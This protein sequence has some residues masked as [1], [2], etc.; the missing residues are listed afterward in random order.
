MVEVGEQRYAKRFVLKL[1]ID[2]VGGLDHRRL[3]LPECLLT[4]RSS[5]SGLLATG[6][7]A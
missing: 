7:R 5:R 2:V 6:G 3:I 4:L 1:F